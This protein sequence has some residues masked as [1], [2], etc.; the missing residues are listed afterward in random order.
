[1]NRNISSNRIERGNNHVTLELTEPQVNVITLA[2]DRGAITLSFNPNGRG[3]G[4]LA[5]TNNERVTLFEILGLK[6]ADPAAEPFLTEIYR[7][8]DRSTNRFTDRGRLIESYTAPA[9]NDRQRQQLVPITPAPSNVPATPVRPTDGNAA[10]APAPPTAS[11]IFL[12]QQN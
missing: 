3:N 2:R 9:L 10:D 7:G 5:L 11:R 8:S 1:V 12:N 4:G 6:P